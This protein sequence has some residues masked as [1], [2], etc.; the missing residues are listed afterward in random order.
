MNA[1]T[2]AHHLGLSWARSTQ[3]MLPSHTL[4]LNLSVIF[5]STPGS[6]KWSPSLRSPNQDPVY[7]SP[8]PVHATCPAH[9]ILLD[10]INRTLF[11]EG[12]RSLSSSLCYLVHL[13]PKYSPQHP[14]LKHPQPTFLSQCE[15]P[16]N[17]N[18]GHH[19]ANRKH[20]N[21]SLS[22]VAWH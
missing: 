7:T 18:N 8:L 5:P 10:F 9:H 6:S 16:G 22:F 17:G 15:R 20:F 12:Y 21:P 3:T 4:K 11:G 14:I 2:E 1:F 13:R 19:K